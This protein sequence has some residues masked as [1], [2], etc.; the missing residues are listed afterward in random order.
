MNFTFIQRK[1]A[2]G[3]IC[4]RGVNE[5]IL[6]TPVYLGLK[7]RPG[8]TQK[9]AY[10]KLMKLRILIILL[11]LCPSLNFSVFA[12]NKKFKIS[13]KLNSEVQEIITLAAELHQFR[14]KKNEEEATKVAKTLAAELS[15]AKEITTKVE[16]LQDVHIAKILDSAYASLKI[17]NTNP[18]SKDA[19]GGLKGFFK[20]MVQIT[21]VLEVKKYR[22]FFC[23]IDRSLWLQKDSKAKNPVN[24]NHVNCGKPV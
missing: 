4:L 16:D 12:S 6:W 9:I 19:V 3:N 24:L 23:P 1:P 22:L 18:K 10:P 20:E 17:Y 7:T 2:V 8:K 14:V 13:N 15:H 5:N 11:F 21:Q